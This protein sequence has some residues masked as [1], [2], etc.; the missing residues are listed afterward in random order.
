MP[1]SYDRANRILAAHVPGVEQ[2]GKIMEAR[3]PFMTAGDRILAGAGPRGAGGAA[4]KP[5]P[6]GWG[7]GGSG[8]L[9][10]PPGRV[11]SPLGAAIAA[12]AAATAEAGGVVNINVWA[13]KLGEAGVSSD[14][15]R[16]A[17]D[18]AGGDG[19][20]APAESRGDTS[21][22]LGEFVAGLEAR[23]VPAEII[24]SAYQAA[25][26]GSSAADG[27]GGGRYS[28]DLRNPG[29]AA[30]GLF[31]QVVGGAEHAAGEIS[32]AFKG[33]F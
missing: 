2:A 27:G 3:L 14:A 18:G 23:G 24:V 10:V 21:Q 16:G 4:E 1:T 30:A 19:A 9:R 28:G 11:I 26:G 12:N 29:H 7:A 22:F 6:G 31:G 13:A 33:M 15:I 8:P 25:G 17:Y 20:L 32:K 5:A